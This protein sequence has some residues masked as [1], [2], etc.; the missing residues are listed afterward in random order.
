MSMIGPFLLSSCCRRRAAS[1][2]ELQVPARLGLDSFFTSNSLT[3]L[4][5]KFHRPFIFPF[6]LLVFFLLLPPPLLSL[7]FNTSFPSFH[8]TLHS[9]LTLHTPTHTLSTHSTHSLPPFFRFQQTTPF[10]SSS[11]I[12]IYKMTDDKK[13]AGPAPGM[14]HADIAVAIQADKDARGVDRNTQF[15]KIDMHTYVEPHHPFSFF[16]LLPCLLSCSSYSSFGDLM[17][18]P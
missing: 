5:L 11:H 15:L 3:L 7:V 2:C 17:Y 16:L 18:Y 10:F 9:P 6:P 8:S 14:N 1:N 4:P 12:P 13:P